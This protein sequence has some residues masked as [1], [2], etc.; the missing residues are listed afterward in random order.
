[1]YNR[2]FEDIGSLKAEVKSI[3]AKQDMLLSMLGKQEELSV[4]RAEFR[5]LKNV[6]SGALGIIIGAISYIYVLIIGG[7]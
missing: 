1:M 3:N 7:R 5:F 4:S 2:L 6:G